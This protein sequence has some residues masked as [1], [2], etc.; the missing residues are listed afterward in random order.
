MKNSEKI[1]L[2]ITKINLSM[3]KGNFKNFYACKQKVK[4]LYKRYLKEKEKEVFFDFL[5]K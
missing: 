3:Q 4:T 2:Q 1:M 5:A